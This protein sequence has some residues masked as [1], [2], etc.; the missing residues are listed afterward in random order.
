MRQQDFLY[1]VSK[2]LVVRTPETLYTSPIPLLLS[3]LPGV[4]V[5]NH[6]MSRVGRAHKG[7]REVG[8]TKTENVQPSD[9]L[10]APFKVRNQRCTSKDIL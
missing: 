2:V 7:C 9:N 1:C 10:A 5:V 8:V 3:L 6:P 4:S